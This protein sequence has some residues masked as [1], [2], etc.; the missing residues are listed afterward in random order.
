M[1]CPEG[2]F[3]VRETGECV[4]ECPMGMVV[5]YDAPADYPNYND[6]PAYPG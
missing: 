6:T 3:E 4:L 1:G 2:E 5:M